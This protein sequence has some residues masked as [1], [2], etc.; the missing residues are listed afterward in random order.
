MRKGDKGV[1]IGA[2]ERTKYRTVGRSKK[3]LE[4]VDDDGARGDE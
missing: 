3:A 4:A 1:V 2:I